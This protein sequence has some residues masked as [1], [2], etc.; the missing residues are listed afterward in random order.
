MTGNQNEDGKI[1]AAVEPTAPDNYHFDVFM[2]YSRKDEE[3]SKKLEEALENYRLPKDVKASVSSKNRLNIFRD[4]KDLVP[5]DGDYFKTI[6][7]YLKNSRYLIIICS[8]NAR[9]SQF[10]NQEIETFLKSHTADRIIPILL[11]GRPNNET[12]ASPEE[13][14][15]PPA[16]CAALA[17]P[18][19][20]GFTEFQRAPGKLNRGPYRDSWYALLSKIFGTQRAEIERLDA[21]RQARRRALFAA[22]SLAVIA[23]LS[24]AL[25][26]A[27]I[28]RQEAVRQR[29]Q[30]RRL[31]YASDMNLA[32]RSFDAGNIALGISLLESHRPRSGEEDL[33]GFEW[34]YLWRLYNGQLATFAATADLAFSS[35]GARFAT[36][37]ADSVK[38]WDA[39]TLRETSN[40]KLSPQNG[41]GGSDDLTQSIDFSPDGRTVAYGN[42]EGVSLL[43]VGSGSARKLPPPGK[44]LGLDSLVGAV[45]SEDFVQ[46]N[47]WEMVKGGIPRFSPNGKLLAVSY[48]CGLVAVYDAQS[49]QQLKRLG[50][51]PPA[52][53]CASFLTFSPDSRVLAYGNSYSVSLWDTVTQQKLGEPELDVDQPDHIDQVEST[54]AFSPDGKILAIG[55]RSKQ[56]VIWNIST[57]KVLARLTGHESWV[58]ALAFSRDGKT[59]FSGSIDHTVKLWDLSSYKG[60][61]QINPDRIKVLAT[62]KGHTGRIS[63]IKSSPA[64]R[65]VATIGADDTVKLWDEAAG[66]EFESIDGVDFVSAGGTLMT[67]SSEEEDTSTIVDLRSGGATPW[68]KRIGD[69]TLSPD[70]K[71]LV[72]VADTFSDDAFNVAAVIKLWDLGS[73]QEVATLRGRSNHQSAVFSRDGRLFSGIGVGGKSLI[74]WDT[75]ARKELAPINSDAELVQYVNSADGK[76]IVTVDKDSGRLRSWVVASQKQLAVIERKPKNH[77]LD[78]DTGDTEGLMKLALSPDGKLLALSDSNV[79]ELWDTSSTQLTTL[80]GEPG[81]NITTLAFSPDGKLIVAGDEAGVVKLWDVATHALLS[82][83]MGHK[84][85]VTTVTFSPDGRTLASGSGPRDG[86]VKLYS[87]VAMREL[88]TF[89]HE[90]SPTA[91]THAAQGGEDEVRQLLFSA[92]GKS[93]ITLANNRVLRIW[94]GAS[95]EGG[96][97]P[98][99]M[100]MGKAAEVY[101]ACCPYDKGINYKGV[102]VLHLGNGLK[103]VPLR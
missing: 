86:S 74:L 89:T 2:S 8:P 102:S 83:F 40:I 72:A 41:A 88:L 59:L 82:A 6:E 4:K 58:T 16:L 48:G 80:P 92:N 21:K 18:L 30:A 75:V 3:F 67:K 31:L 11:S 33:R 9:G 5:T 25:I 79:V 51:G 73:R 94:R 44:G 52:S 98:P 28:S 57:R 42:D 43:D 12:E 64:G 23:L 76:M 68:K 99:E 27:I 32:Q 101:S 91:E 69:A 90:P 63:S 100:G 81:A 7:G 49:L 46:P 62:L 85:A 87:V 29:D 97:K 95:D 66:R 50:D 38:I 22:V 39:A 15:F 14:A 70:G 1:V 24:V 53:Y 65:I 34:Y 93:L 37:T 20:L 96:G 56:V 17:M 35:D 54:V 36:A 47:Y 26:F 61:G 78:A 10:V 13:H 45:E 19:A 60:G 71:T 103:R 84:D 77:Q 55:D